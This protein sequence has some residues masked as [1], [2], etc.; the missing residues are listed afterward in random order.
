MQ[1]QKT[2]AR[3]LTWPSLLELSNE[4][5]PIRVHYAA[6][7]LVIQPWEANHLPLDSLG[8]PEFW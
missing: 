4:T 2:S 3:E 6:Q 1:T 8:P 5:A 7:K